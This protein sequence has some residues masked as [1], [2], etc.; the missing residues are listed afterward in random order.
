MMLIFEKIT[1]NYP[2][3]ILLLADETQE[4]IDRYVFESDV[5]IVKDNDG[6]L[7][8]VFCLQVISETMIELKN[9]A[10]VEEYQN[11]EI[12]SQVILYIK[13]LCKNKYPYLLVGTPDCAI[14][15][16]HFYEKNGFVRFMIKQNFYINNYP[17]PIFENGIQLKD[18]LVLKYNL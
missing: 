16:I 17:D 1:E 11:K 10:I 15:Q 3:P 5:Y 7:I 18:M 4:A 9:I 14:H 12:G 6:K 8:G 13:K 2:Y